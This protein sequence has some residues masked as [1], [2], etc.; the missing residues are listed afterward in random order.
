MELITSIA[1][2]EGDGALRWAATRRGGRRKP[3]VRPNVPSGAVG[4][5][6]PPI[7][8]C[9][10]LVLKRRTGF[11]P[12][13]RRYGARPAIEGERASAIGGNPGVD[14]HGRAG[15][16]SASAQQ[17]RTPRRGSIRAD[18]FPTR[19]VRRDTRRRMSVATAPV[20]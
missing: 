18:G 1:S 20:K 17:A 5:A 13:A 15:K 11:L 16:K 14:S 4:P 12:P 9:G 7:A 19:D 2:T 8:A 6:A 3:P 10:L